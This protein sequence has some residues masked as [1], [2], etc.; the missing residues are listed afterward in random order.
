L[1]QQLPPLILSLLIV[2]KAS[3]QS[4]KSGSCKNVMIISL[5]VMVFGL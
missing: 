3:P 5:L 1:E 4:G 2:V